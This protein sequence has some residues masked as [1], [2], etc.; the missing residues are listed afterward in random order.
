MGTYMESVDG[1]AYYI[2]AGDPTK[3]SEKLTDVV[4]RGSLLD[5]M[6][7]NSDIVFEEDTAGLFFG[8]GI[9]LA[10]IGS[11]IS[12]IIWT[13]TSDAAGWL[14]FWITLVIAGSVS[15]GIPV[16]LFLYFVAGSITQRAIKPQGDW[17]AEFESRTTVTR[18]DDDARP[19][20]RALGGQRWFEEHAEEY[21]EA[22]DEFLGRWEV[23]RLEELLAQPGIERTLVR[24]CESELARIAKGSVHALVVAREQEQQREVEEAAALNNAVLKDFLDTQ[25]KSI[26]TPEELPL[27]RDDELDELR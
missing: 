11:F 2:A 19:A 6:T 18:V 9:L 23:T 15:I 17:A 20:V 10:I 14:S 21:G 5:R 24:E 12:L 26:T 13:M 22:I 1:R 8:L 7:R 25:V 4:K 27:L 3:G 16:L